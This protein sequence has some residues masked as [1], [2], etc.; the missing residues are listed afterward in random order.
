MRC[1]VAIKRVVDPYVHIR[2][3]SDG[4][5]VDTD[6]VKMAMNPFDEIAVEEAVRLKEKGIV[7][8]IK[9]LSI[10]DEKCQ[11]ILRQALALGADSAALIRC[12]QNLSPL[13]VAK[14]IAK[15]VENYDPEIIILGKQSIDGDNN[16]TGQMLSALLN[17]G[18]ATFVS[19]V[20]LQDKKLVVDR[21]VDE[22]I[23]T[24][25]ID[26]PAV[27]TTDLRLNE[28]RYA[29]LPNVMKAKSKPLEIIDIDDFGLSLESKL[30]TLEVSA[31]ET[32]TRGEIVADVSE[33][34]D[35]LKNE[36]KVI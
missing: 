36:A 8:E 1:L 3:R 30:E 34:I 12:G 9:V 17:W 13:H 6:N 22:G 5:G 18:Q 4:S 31:P 26:L 16:Q 23:E 21:E 10:G 2:V 11:E 15:F 28:P 7:S 20:E 35:K 29:T 27:I 33:L 24:I 25:E 19:K 32:R 14:V